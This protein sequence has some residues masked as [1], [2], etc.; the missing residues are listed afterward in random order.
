MSTQAV[1]DRSRPTESPDAPVMEIVSH[2]LDEVA[3]L[4]QEVSGLRGRVKRLEDRSG[5]GPPHPSD[6]LDPAVRSA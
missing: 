1:H 4:K 6:V 3:D 2:L 5:R